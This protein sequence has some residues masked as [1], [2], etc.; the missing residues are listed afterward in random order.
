MNRVRIKVV[1]G[2]VSGFL[3]GCA[4][5]EMGTT[6]AG[7]RTVMVGRLPSPAFFQSRLAVLF[8]FAKNT[9]RTKIIRRNGAI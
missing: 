8:P 1:Q 7:C 6:P 4:D 2:W 5:L 3:V 9:T